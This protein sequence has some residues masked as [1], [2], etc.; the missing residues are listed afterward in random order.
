MTGEVSDGHSSCR[1]LALVAFGP[2]GEPTGGWGVRAAI[3]ADVLVRQG[4]LAWVVAVGGEERGQTEL[5]WR[6]HGVVAG[7]PGQE[8][9]QLTA[10][11]LHGV[12]SGPWWRWMTELAVTARRLRHQ[13]D[14]FV[15]ESALLGLPV[16]AAGRPVVWDTNECET[17]HYGRMP[18]TAATMAKRAVWRM[19]E[20]LMVRTSRVVVAISEEEAGHWQRLF[21]SSAGKLLVCDHVPLLAPRDRPAGSIPGGSAGTTF[22][23]SVADPARGVPIGCRQTVLFVGPLAAKHNAVAA[24]WCITELAPALPDGVTVV[25]AGQGTDELVASYGGSE[26]VVGLGFVADLDTLIVGADL[27]V[28][29]LAAGAG[30][31]TKVLHALALGQ[32]VVGTPLAFEGIGAVAGCIEVPLGELAAT[33]ARLLSHE[34]PAD[35]RARRQAAQREWRDALVD[36]G[37]LDRQWAAVVQRLCSGQR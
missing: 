16:L 28:A 21:P 15:V 23:P 27:C 30:T 36:A 33:V 22:A 11:P 3:V 2:F 24:R 37:R 9:Q 13:V 32:R 8:S 5:W 10:L 26:R 31:K 12:P 4:T 17:L 1:W 19:L 6:R 29:P 18:R 35:E 14:G 34:E 7:D 20:W 25:L